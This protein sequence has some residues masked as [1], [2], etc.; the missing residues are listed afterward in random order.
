MKTMELFE[1]KYRRKSEEERE[2]QKK[3]PDYWRLQLRK[4]LTKFNQQFGILLRRSLPFSKW[5][6]DVAILGGEYNFLVS[7]DN[8]SFSKEKRL[9]LWKK[10]YAQ[11]ILQLVK[12]GHTVWLSM[13]LRSKEVKPTDTVDDI[14]DEF[15]REMKPIGPTSDRHPLQFNYKIYVKKPDEAKPAA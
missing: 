1:R 8:L 13:Q 11:R 9:E 2:A 10:A 15:N 7:G 14:L 5:A 4:E 3:A 12:S 6:G